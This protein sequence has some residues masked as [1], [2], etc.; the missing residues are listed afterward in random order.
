MADHSKDKT[1]T[2][3]VNV[4]K[5]VLE[6]YDRLYPHTRRRFICEAM[7]MATESR[8]VFDKIFFRELLSNHDSN[9]IL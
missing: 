1:L 5:D 2:V 9:S 7:K 4:D 3:H 6:L 8:E